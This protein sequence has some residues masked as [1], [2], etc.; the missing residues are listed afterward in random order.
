MGTLIG[1]FILQGLID[2]IF[3][4]Y[5]FAAFIQYLFY[6]IE[7]RYDYIV[8]PW[9]KYILLIVLIFTFSKKT[10]VEPMIYLSEKQDVNALLLNMINMTCHAMVSQILYGTKSTHISLK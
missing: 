10:L 7:A 3:W 8:G 2:W 1:L 5:P 9:Y 4:G 6:N